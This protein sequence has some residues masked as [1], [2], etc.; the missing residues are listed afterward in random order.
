MSACVGVV[1]THDPRCDDGPCSAPQEKSPPRRRS[2]PAFA[3]RLTRCPVW[4][5]GGSA[6]CELQIYVSKRAAD[7]TE[8][9]VPLPLTSFGHSLC[10]QSPRESPGVLSGIRAGPGHSSQDLS[11]DLRK[12]GTRDPQAAPGPRPLLT[13]HLTLLPLVH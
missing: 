5:R 1:F 8:G 9:T 2:P 11:Q 6:L 12:A 10:P 7:P 4:G 3:Q 13:H